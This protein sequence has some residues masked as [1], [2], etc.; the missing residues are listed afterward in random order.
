[1]KCPCC[2][3]TNI[4]LNQTCIECWWH[5]SN[6]IQNNIFCSENNMT[7]GQAKYN[8]SILGIISKQY[9]TLKANTL[10]KYPEMIGDCCD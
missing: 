3:K 6:V 5:C 2:N 9:K 1:M 4:E 8:Y 10:Q 7:L